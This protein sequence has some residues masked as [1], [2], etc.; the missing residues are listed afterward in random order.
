MHGVLD[1]TK[2]IFVTI[3]LIGIFVDVI[4]TI[5]NIVVVDP[6]ICVA[7]LQKDFHPLLC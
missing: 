1:A 2:A 4:T 3:A 5:N 6:F 7:N